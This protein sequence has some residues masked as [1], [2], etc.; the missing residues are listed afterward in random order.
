[1]R[2]MSFGKRV[3]MKDIG[4]KA[5]VSI[6]TVS[7]ALRNDPRLPKKTIERVQQAAND[8]GYTP[9][10]WL[11]SLSSYRRADVSGGRN[12]TVAILSN[13]DT[14]DGWRESPTIVNYHTGA[15]RMA[16]QL[17][18]R[19]EEFWVKENG[20][21]VRTESILYNRGI[22]GVL[23]LPL[24]PDVFHTKFDLSRFSVVQVGQR[25][26]WPVLNTVMHNHYGA[27]QMTVYQLRTL[28]YTRI[29]LVIPD[30]ITRLHRYSWLA[31]FLAKQYDFTE[32]MARLPILRT[33]NL[34]DKVFF[35]W[36]KEN[37]CDVVIGA[38]YQPYEHMLNAGMRVP[39]DIGFSCLCMEDAKEKNVSGIFMKSETAG[40][41][42]MN[43]LHMLMMSGQ[44]GS[45]NDP[46]T[47][48]IEGEWYL[49]KTLCQQTHTQPPASPV[50]KH[51]SRRK[52]V[53]A[54]S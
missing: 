49:R 23:L 17:G 36:L 22:K 35:D 53:V 19:I 47:Q 40:A 48:V 20:G 41:Q 28:G 50:R 15:R 14:R 27:M 4:E 12:S 33:D 31:A 2:E 13:W 39:E 34:T 9:D 29:G 6:S 38:N 10:P 54:N 21:E 52:K 26:S 37:R 43:L 32:E 42:A 46:I 51:V 24:P 16:Y 7:L 18:Y 44:R 5:G 1:M 3:T 30:K 45:G 11:S 8:L 25:I